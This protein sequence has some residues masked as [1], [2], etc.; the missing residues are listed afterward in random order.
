[1]K[2]KDIIDGKVKIA[3]ELYDAPEYAKYIAKDCDGYWFFY[4]CLPIFDISISE[5]AWP[6][7]AE[8]DMDVDVCFCTNKTKPISTT[9]AAKKVFKLVRGKS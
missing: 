5:W 2:T 1:M 3:G 7:G 9:K 8:I 4:S 6:P